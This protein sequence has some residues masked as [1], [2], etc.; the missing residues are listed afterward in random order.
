MSGTNSSQSIRRLR[1]ASLWTF[2]LSLFAIVLFSPLNILTKLDLDDTFWYAA[3]FVAA[4]VA[5]LAI[6][7][8]LIALDRGQDEARDEFVAV[9]TGEPARDRPIILLL[10]PFDFAEP[11][12]FESA[13]GQ[14][15]SGIS[16][17]ALLFG[18][19]VR[20]ITAP[21]TLPY[22]YGSFERE[23]GTALASA[24]HDAVDELDD[25]ID[26]RTLLVAIGNRCVSCGSDKFGLNDKDGPETFRRLAEVAVLIVMVPDTSPAVLWELS[27]IVPSRDFLAKTAFIMPRGGSAKRWAALAEY[28]AEKLGATLPG[29]DGSGGCFRLT[30]DR[31]PGKT[32]A[33]ES[34]T[35]GLQGYLEDAATG[36]FSVAEL[37]KSVETS[38]V[39]SS[40]LPQTAPDWARRVTATGYVD[41]GEALIKQLGGTVVY[42]ESGEIFTRTEI[43]VRVFGVEHSFESQYDMVQWII[44]DVV[45]RVMSG[46]ANPAGGITTDRRR[47]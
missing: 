7:F 31:Q 27:H 24:I 22:S 41:D 30:S 16:M 12:A 39:V 25:A 11:G 17:V 4:A 45:A 23:L 42:Q 9:L 5:V 33:L 19:A 10:L 38:P 28:A 3:P 1:N 36:A 14:L 13:A 37:W 40:V 8:Y 21:P 20:P 32:A 47:P 35:S 46:P 18:A 29:H 26:S 43:T 2:W 15:L 44:K 34:F 6:T